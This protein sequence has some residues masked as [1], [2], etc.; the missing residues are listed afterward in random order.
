MKNLLNV[1][2]VKFV[3]LAISTSACIPG[4]SRG[5]EVDDE[6]TA[7][8][9]DIPQG[10]N[11]ARFQPGSEPFKK[12]G[13]KIEIPLTFEEDGK[14]S[15]DLRLLSISCN[16]VINPRKVEFEDFGPK[17][18]LMRVSADM[19]GNTT[20]CQSVVVA[21]NAGLFF[22]SPMNERIELPTDV[23]DADKDPSIYEKMK[24]EFKGVELPLH[25]RISAEIAKDIKMAE[26][27]KRMLE[28]QAILS[29]KTQHELQ[30]KIN[31][32]A[33][34][35]AEAAALEKDRL[36]AEKKRLEAEKQAQEAE[37]AKEMAELE[38]AIKKEQLELSERLKQ[39]EKE[40]REEAEKRLEEKKKEIEDKKRELEETEEENDNLKKAAE[41]K[42][43]VIE[44]SET[45]I[46]ECPI[47]KKLMINT[48]ECK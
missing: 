5:I 26:D 1:V 14:S 13:Y 36:L 6:E 24:V 44:V 35:E 18:I 48:L 2:L 27:R 43:D 28:Q 11:D 4:G 20:T 37:L 25:S 23:E 34:K 32:I 3:A 8:S 41:L 45:T 10:S 33:V 22:E 39:R 17:T 9:G 12:F 21:D 30:E 46:Y 15:E 31:A 19:L 38:A 40:I 7:T 29:K 42:V 16:P 47:G